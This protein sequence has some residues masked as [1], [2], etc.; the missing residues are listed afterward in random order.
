LFISVLLQITQQDFA[1][2][3]VFKS[4]HSNVFQHYT[5][6]QREGNLFS[7]NPL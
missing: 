4:K 2:L 1:M 3:H 5:T 6:M 7:A